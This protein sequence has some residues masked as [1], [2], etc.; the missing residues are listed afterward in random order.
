MDHD[1][2]TIVRRLWPVALCVALLGM[3]CAVGLW[4]RTEGGR[5]IDFSH[6]AHLKQSLECADCHAVDSKTGQ[7]S[8]SLLDTCQTC[9]EGRDKQK[10]EAERVTRFYVDGKAA[11]PFFTPLPS[12]TIFDHRAHVGYKTAC[13]DCHGDVAHSESVGPE[14]KVTMATCTTCHEARAAKSTCDTCHREIRQDQKP[15][16]HDTQF[17]RTHGLDLHGV[18][19]RQCALCHTEASCQ[20]CHQ[21]MQPANHTNQFRRRGHGLVA[22]MDRRECQTCHQS[23]FC[24]RCHQDTRPTDHTAS[25]G[26]TRSRHCLSCHIPVSSEPRCSVC[27]NGTPSHALATPKPPNHAP[28]LN[29]R[30][31]HGIS[32]PLPHVDNGGDCNACHH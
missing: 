1:V 13:T 29:C 20:G 17:M 4:N 30:Q 32:A 21:Q 31:C 11:G 14:V 27:H 19:Q 22:S 23:D 15:P 9:H 7:P 18:E 3:G 26:G 2:R 5:R 12:E 24:V 16:S 10:P 8:R 6:A 25:W 28:G